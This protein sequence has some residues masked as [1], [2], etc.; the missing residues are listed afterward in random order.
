LTSS[1]TI[2]ALVACVERRPCH[3][4]FLEKD[5]GGGRSRLCARL[6]AARRL[7]ES[8][9]PSPTGPGRARAPVAFFEPC[10]GTTVYGREGD[11]LGT[12]AAFI[13]DRFTGQTEYIVITIGGQ[14]VCRHQLSAM[15]GADRREI[16]GREPAIAR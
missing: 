14:F 10:E 12:V 9:Q 13:F 4:S 1:S 15:F 8:G 3:D 5:Y 16:I 11:K 2:E 6:T 7:Y